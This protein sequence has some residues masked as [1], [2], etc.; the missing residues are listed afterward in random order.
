MTKHCI[1]SMLHGWSLVLIYFIIYTRYVKQSGL[2]LSKTLLQMVDT[3]FSTVYL[4]LKS[5]QNIYAELQ[6]KMEARGEGEK[7][8]NVAP[9]TLAFLVQFLKIFW[10]AQR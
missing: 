8:D 1:M 2:A 7:V 4:S 5:I 3:R 9:D 10:D 6:E